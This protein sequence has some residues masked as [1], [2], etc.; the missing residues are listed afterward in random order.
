MIPGW[1]SATP[2]SGGDPRTPSKA[3]LRGERSAA[4]DPQTLVR[5]AL[6]VVTTGLLLATFALVARAY[7]PG[8]PTALGRMPG[9]V[10]LMLLLAGLSMVLTLAPPTGLTTF[11][12]GQT[13]LLVASATLLAVTLSHRRQHDSGHRGDL[14][15]TGTVDA[16]TRIA[17]HRVFQDR[18]VHECERAYRFGDTFMLV[19][20]D[21]DNFHAVNN[22][23]GHRTGDMILLD[24]AR[25][26]KAQLRD[27][28]LVAR[29]GGDRFAMIL[30]H[31][32]ENG[33]VLVAERIRQNVAGWV[34]FTD[35]GTEVRLTVSV[36]MCS[37]PAD[38][39]AAPELVGAGR[40]SPRLR[41]GHGRQPDT[42]LP[43]ASGQGDAR[44][45]GLSAPLRSRSHRQ[46]PG[47]GRGHQRRLHPHSLDH[48]SR[49]WPRQSPGVSACRRPR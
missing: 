32:Y 16:L 47:S 25:R 23:H 29:F 49:S 4:I 34:F 9:A 37:Y 35:D 38:G 33:G 10:T 11:P 1:S 40:Q 42:A 28:D 8:T 19:L 15:D 44:Q 30:P 7:R 14:V 3:S 6:A 21:L 41:Q 18:L 13:I 39:A 43:R 20:L 26:I 31:T 45:R 46:E 12:V 17:S 27:I 5:I 36:G 2:S 22:R 48:L 24:L